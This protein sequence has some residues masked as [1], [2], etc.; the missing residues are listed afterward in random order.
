MNCEL[1]KHYYRVAENMDSVPL[2]DH[3][4]HGFETKYQFRD[5]VRLLLNRWHGREG[6]GIGIKN[7]FVLLHFC[8]SLGGLHEEAWLPD[9]LLT[10]IPPPK[11]LRSEERDETEEEIDKAFG[12]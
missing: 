6:E 2:R 12:F 5:A 4:E 7:N 8:D 1:K 9:F 11:Y 10:P 3:L